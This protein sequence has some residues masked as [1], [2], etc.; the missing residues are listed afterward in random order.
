M[1]WMVFKDKKVNGQCERARGPIASC[2][3]ERFAFLYVSETC[4]G[5]RKVS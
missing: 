2:D 5:R 4:V 3:K 1:V